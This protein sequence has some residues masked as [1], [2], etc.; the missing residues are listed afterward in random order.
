MVGVNIRILSLGEKATATFLDDGNDGAVRGS[1][2]FARG[3]ARDDIK[4]KRTEHGERTRIKRG[5]KRWWKISTGNWRGREARGEA[6][7]S[8]EIA[9]LAANELP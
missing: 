8:R 1:P 7:R 6:R 2:E 5:Y 9:S 4:I 3:V